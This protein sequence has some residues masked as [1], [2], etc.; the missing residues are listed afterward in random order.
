MNNICSKK[1]ASPGMSSGSE[2]CPTCTLRATAAGLVASLLLLLLEAG[3]FEAL[4][5]RGSPP[6]QEA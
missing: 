3:A 1:C 6:D 4:G 2:K 5:C